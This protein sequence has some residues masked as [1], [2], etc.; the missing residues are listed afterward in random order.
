MQCDVICF[1]W[2][3]P[4]ALTRLLSLINEFL[5]IF[6]FFFKSTFFEVFRFQI[7]LRKA[8]QPDPQS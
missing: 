5:A 1:A 6:F 3:P 2:N 8:N 4:S 7:F